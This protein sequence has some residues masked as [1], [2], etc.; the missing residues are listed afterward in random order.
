MKD[1]TAAAIVVGLVGSRRSVDQVQS[2]DQ[3]IR[4]V[5]TD[6]LPEDGSFYFSAPLTYLGNKLTSYGGNLNYTIVYVAGTAGYT[7]SAPDIILIGGDFTLY[8][9]GHETPSSSVPL[10]VSVEINERNFVLP[11]GLPASRENLLVALKDV[12]GL[13]IR[14]SYSDPTREARLSSV[15]MEIAVKELIDD[16]DVAVAVEQCNCPVNYQGTSCEDCAPG[17]FRAHTGPYGGFC[18]P[19]QCNEKKFLPSHFGY[20]LLTVSSN[21]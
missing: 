9:F 2:Y 1:W 14:G 3:M 16:A 6:F 11:S 10:S 12:R 18:V 13:Y 7:V 5:L 17:H 20:Y 8:H 19:C 21:V 4:A 15:I